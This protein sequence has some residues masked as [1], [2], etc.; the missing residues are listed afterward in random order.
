MEVGKRVEQSG[1]YVNCSVSWL[2]WWVQD[3]T[4]VKTQNYI[5]RRMSFYCTW[6]IHQWIWLK[7]KK[8]WYRT[9]KTGFTLVLVYQKV[10][11]AFMSVY[12]YQLSCE[13]LHILMCVCLCV[14]MIIMTKKIVL[15]SM[16]VCRVLLKVVSRNSFVLVSKFKHLGINSLNNLQGI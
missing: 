8:H 7:R 14:L 15:L 10:F 9:S 6:I 13:D 11:N 5:L 2:L 1:G 4:F 3:Y 12:G 16:R